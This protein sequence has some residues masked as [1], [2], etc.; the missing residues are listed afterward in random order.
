MSQVEDT[1][2]T[3]PLPKV[4]DEIAENHPDQTWMYIPKNDNVRNGYREVS[5]SRLARVVNKMARWIERTVGTSDSRETI[6]YM[7][8]NDTRYI[9]TVLAALKTGYKIMLTSTRNSVEGQ[10]SLVKATDCKKF[11]YS[12]ELKKQVASI[13]DADTHLDMYQIPEFEEILKQQEGGEHYEGRFSDDPNEPAIIIHTSGSTGLPKPIPLRNGYLATV[14]RIYHTPTP[15]HTVAKKIWDERPIFAALPWFHAMGLFM[16]LRSLYNH[17]PLVLLPS[18]VSPNAEGTIEMIKAAKPKHGFFAPS[19]LEDMVEIEGGLE[20]LNSMEDVYFAG[21]PLSHEVGDRIARLPGTKLQTIIGSTEA[22]ITDSFVNEADED[23]EY[24]EWCPYTGAELHPQGDGL[25]EL[26]IKNQHG[27]LQGAFFS[28]PDAEE[29]RTKD[30][31]EEHPKKPGLWRYK[32]RNDDVIVL[33]NGEKFG[34]VDLEKTVEAHPAVKGALVV[35][36]GRFQAGVLIEP[37]SRHAKE[38]QEDPGAFIDTIWPAVEK[39]N[40]TVA[41]HGRVFKSKIAI[42]KPDKPFVRVAKGSIMRRQ[43]NNLYEREIDALYSNESYADQIATLDPSATDEQIKSTVRTALGL[44]LPD[45]P[46]DIDDTAD[47]FNYNIDSLGVLGLAS[48][49]NH[50]MPHGENIIKPRTLYSNPTINGIVSAISSLLHGSQTTTKS[51]KDRMS[52]L[53]SN[54][55]SHLPPRIVPSPTPQSHT[56]ILTGSTGSLGTYILAVLIA[57]P[58]I[59]KIYCLNRSASAAS[60]QTTALSSRSLPS[61]LSKVEFLH[62]PSLGEPRFGLKEAK[63]VE[64]RDTATVFLHN[65]WAVDFNMSLESFE[66]PHIKGVWR[67]VEFSAG[68]R[69]TPRIVFVSSI[70]SVGNWYGN[71]GKGSGKAVP[72]ELLGDDEVALPQGYGESKH[73]AGKLLDAAAETS[74]VPATVVRVGQLAGPVEGHG[75]WNRQ[76]WLPSLV[77]S[78]QALGKVPRRLGN[79]DVVDWVPVDVAARVM[80]ELATGEKVDEKMVDERA[81]I[82][83]LVNPK[84]VSWQELCPVVQEYYKGKG[85]DLEAVGFGEWLEALKKVP[86]TR[87]DAERVPGVKLVDFYEGL[88]APQ[89]LPR[90]MTEKTEASSDT[91]RNSEPVTAAMMKKWLDQW[92]F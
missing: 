21:A 86:A 19:I 22:G 29:W 11:L 73:V 59:K 25:S 61:D 41:A 68:A 30:L 37:E 60:R 17:G 80:V 58:H 67:A 55:T 26:V 76:E 92:A 78:S 9:I 88:A 16:M 77:S 33:S 69:Y 34:P 18:A 14:Y 24:F 38:A 91:L 79:M 15:R 65:A 66:D 74:G 10:R 40:G 4:V 75:E 7:G 2:H 84:T 51:R 87:E 81:G 28:F 32:G 27:I 46:S 5:F 50:A 56:V 39:G 72:E 83:H 47:L 71:V 45:V 54:Y 70:A 53:L 8:T 49:L 85:V 13:E 3:I 12:T 48:A 62:A 35:G 44:A 89:G 36:Q 1:R 52:A 6:A 90:L 23:W 20:A 57:S 63:Y 43:T 64:L 31:Y 82:F 42:A